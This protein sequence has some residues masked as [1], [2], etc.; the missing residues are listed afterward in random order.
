MNRPSSFGKSTLAR[1]LQEALY[2]PFL[3]IGIN[4]VIGVMPN[5]LNNWE[6]DKASQRV[7]WKSSIDETSHPVNEIQMGTFV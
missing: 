6:G 1:A 2:Q 5:K 4:R 7:S 3:Y